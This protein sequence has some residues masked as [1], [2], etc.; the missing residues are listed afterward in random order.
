VKNVPIAVYPLNATSS[1]SMPSLI[2]EEMDG[3]D[4]ELKL[5]R[6]QQID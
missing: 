4:K 6:L 1:A 3:L 5:A 2:L